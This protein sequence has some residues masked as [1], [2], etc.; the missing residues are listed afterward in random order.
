MPAESTTNS[1][2]RGTDEYSNQYSPHQRGE[3]SHSVIY[4]PH[5]T[6]FY[7]IVDISL[8]ISIPTQKVIDTNCVSQLY[9]IFRFAYLLYPS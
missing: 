5:T 3:L 1:Y 7:E 8:Q 6:N 2:L 4:T 9:F